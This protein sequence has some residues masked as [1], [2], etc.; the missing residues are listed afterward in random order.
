MLNNLSYMANKISKL[1]FDNHSPRT[2]VELRMTKGGKFRCLGTQKWILRYAQMT[3]YQST[4]LYI[5]LKPKRWQRD[6]LLRLSG[7]ILIADGSTRPI[8]FNRADCE[9]IVLSHR[10]CCANSHESNHLCLILLIGHQGRW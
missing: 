10:G 7:L 1:L 8:Q 4:R 2:T 9:P 3:H 5:R 6:L